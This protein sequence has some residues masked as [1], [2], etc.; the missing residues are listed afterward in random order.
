VSQGIPGL[1]ILAAFCWIGF[2]AAWRSRRVWLAAAL[3]AVLV[4]QMF[5]VFTMPTALVFYVTIAMA[6]GVKQE[7][8]AGSGQTVNWSK[9]LG[10]ALRAAVALALVYGAVRLTLADRDLERAKTA[11]ERSDLAAADASYGQYDRLRFPGVGS[12]LWYS[13]ACSNLAAKTPNPVVRVQALVQA[14]A[15]AVRATRTSDEPFNAWYSLSGLYAAQNDFAGTEKC[16][17][18][19]IAAR[20]NWFKPHWTLA[21]VLR[22]EGRMAEAEREAELAADR[23]G[24]KNPEVGQ[25]LYDIRAL[26]AGHAQP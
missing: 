5:T 6:V 9:K 20:P 24:K 21:Q 1:A 26:R 18:A 13:R 19:A 25:T 12:D 16:L 22:L 8:K 4:S 14:G 15:A 3:A 10:G 23:N 2:S 7:T 11:L 17:R